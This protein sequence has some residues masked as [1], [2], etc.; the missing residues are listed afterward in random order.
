MLN[1]GIKDKKKK[2]QLPLQD[3]YKTN[4]TLMWH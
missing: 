4:E 1:Y 3:R 2:D